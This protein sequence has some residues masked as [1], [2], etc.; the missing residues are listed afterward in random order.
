MSESSTKTKSCLVTGATGFLG[1]NLVHELVRQG[2]KVRAS[3]MHGDD[4]QYI[5]DLPVEYVPA[6]ITKMEEV[7]PLVDGCDVVFHV[8]GDTSFWKKYFKRQRKINVDG[9][10]NVAEACKKHGVKR[11]VHTSTL[12]VLGYNPTGGSYDE[13]TGHYNFDNMGYNY[14]DTKLEAEVL[15]R[16]YNSSQLE[17][18]FIYPGFMM[19]PFDHTLQVGRVFF[20]LSKGKLPALIP[21]GGSYCHVTEVAKA[22]ITAAEKGKPGE[23]YLC[24]GMP[25]TNLPHAEVYRRIAETINVKTPAITISRKVFIVYAYICELVSEF[26]KKAPEINPGQARYLSVPQYA[27]SGKAIDELGYHVPPIETCIQDALTWYRDNGYV[28]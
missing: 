13:K 6:D 10:V 23:G 22:H 8:A 3:G 27:V 4:T 12:D 2:W 1:T 9:A 21:G 11:L 7:E 15:L 5:K 25:H 26:T 16:S 28:I 18:V 14:G 20:E 24:A 17:V 19:G